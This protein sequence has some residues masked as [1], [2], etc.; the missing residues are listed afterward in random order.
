MDGA[1]AVHVDGG[2]REQNEGTGRWGQSKARPCRVC[3]GAGYHIR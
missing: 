3:A 2:P 1:A